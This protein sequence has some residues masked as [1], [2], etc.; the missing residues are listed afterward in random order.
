MFQ[1]YLHIPAHNEG[2]SKNSK[3][4]LNTHGTLE[5]KMNDFEKQ[6]IGRALESC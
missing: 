1:R 6:I 3:K 5:E 2:A 4:T